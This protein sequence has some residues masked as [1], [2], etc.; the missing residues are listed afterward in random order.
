MYATLSLKRAVTPAA[1]ALGSAVQVFLLLLRALFFVIVVY[2][3]AAQSA[4]RTLVQTDIAELA[5][6]TESAVAPPVAETLTASMRAALDYTSRRYRV[7]HEALIPIFAAVQLAA[8]EQDLDPLLIVAVIGIESRFNPFSESSMGA[9][10]L[11]QVIPRFHPDKLPGDAGKL[12]LFDPVANIRVGAW[13]LHD[14]IVRHGDVSGGLQQFAG[15]R[16][17]PEQGYAA[18]V[19]A[20]KERLELVAR[21][22]ADNRLP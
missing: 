19:L 14:Y 3:L 9:Q 1:D 8:R 6:N 21:L 10:G 20:E 17:R 4:A 15:D 18:R 5:A 7:S 22:V 12:H 11:M 2:A 13:A 16:S